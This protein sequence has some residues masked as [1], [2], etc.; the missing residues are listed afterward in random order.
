[1]RAGRWEKWHE[2]KLALPEGAVPRGSRALL[3]IEL[4]V[5]LLEGARRESWECSGEIGFRL[6]WPGETRVEG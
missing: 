1:M 5:V 3:D 6:G 2:L 4:S